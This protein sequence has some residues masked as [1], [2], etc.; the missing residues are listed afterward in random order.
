MYLL[1]V[2]VKGLLVVLYS[3]I[4]LLFKLEPF[5]FQVYDHNLLEVWVNGAIEIPNEVATL[6]YGAAGTFNNVEVLV[7]KLYE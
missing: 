4:L 3:T 5:V 7:E 2:A 6:S 1:I